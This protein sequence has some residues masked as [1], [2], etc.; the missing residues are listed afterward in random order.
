MSKYRNSLPQLGDKLF[1][2][3]SGLETTLI[4]NDGLDLP[5]FAAFD[6]LK[7]EAIRAILEQDFPIVQGFVLFIAVV[8]VL[9]NLVVDL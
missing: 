3:D 7:D 6:L 8:Y 9:T 2:T 5:H 1:T 4:F